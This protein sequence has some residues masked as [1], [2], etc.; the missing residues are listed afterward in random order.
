[1]SWSYSKDPADSDLDAVRFYVQDTDTEDQLLSDEEI[2]FLITQW[3]PTYGSLIM[4]ASMAAEAL[5]AKF[6][7]EV[8]YSADGVSVGVNELQQKYDALASSLR[9][10]YKQQVLGGGPDV[11]GIM[12]SDQPDQSIRPTIWSIGMHDNVR[13][14]SQ[15]YEQGG[16]NGVP[17]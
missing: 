8:S 13:A 11:G 2:E 10:Q 14:G 6:A 15:S 4:V 7:R 1:M 17:F 9:D 5:A 3:N 16:E 12:Y